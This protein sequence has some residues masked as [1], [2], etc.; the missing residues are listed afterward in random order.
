M[1]KLRG[2]VI[3]AVFLALCACERQ[4]PTPQTPPDWVVEANE[5]SRA[6]SAAEDAEPPRSEYL[7][8]YPY[9]WRVTSDSGAV[10]HLLGSYHIGTD[11]SG[12]DPLPPSVRD[13]FEQSDTIVL[14]ADVDPSK[15]P[16]EQLFMKAPNG[17]RKQLTTEQ[18]DKLVSIAGMPPQALEHL[19]PWIVWSILTVKLTPGATEYGM[20][21]RFG[22]L[23][24]AY[25]K[26]RQHLETINEQIELL[27]GLF[28][29]EDIA[30]I[31]DNDQEVEAGA[32]QAMQVFRSGKAQSIHDFMPEYADEEIPADV[33]DKLL[34]QR[35]HNWVKT[36]EPT[37]RADGGLLV[38][39]GTGHLLGPQSVVELL[40][41]K[42][43]LTVERIDAP[44]E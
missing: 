7:V 8:E 6:A 14:E 37:L 15:L 36:L 22:I 2:F 9:L 23:A 12:L 3:I 31:L 20:D 1:L 34:V 39:V 33:L 18:W 24:D 38:V 27:S 42:E 19:K 44:P 30:E 29:A 21:R 40:A 10:S 13:A 26:D 16:P 35:N 43:G 17:L 32:R 11:F 41:N 5:R 28:A 4:E 25:E